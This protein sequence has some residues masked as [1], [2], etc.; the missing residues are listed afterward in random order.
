MAK[1][2]KKAA[3][4]DVEL[5]RWCIEQAMRWPMISIGN[6]GGAQSLMPRTEQEADILNRAL[7]IRAWVL[8]TI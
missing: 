1:T 3:K 2:A 6:Y 5:N 8:T 4:P 7:R